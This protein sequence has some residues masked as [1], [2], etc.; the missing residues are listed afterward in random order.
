MVESFAEPTP[1]T[2]FQVRTIRGATC[3]LCALMTLLS[4]ACTGS[5]GKAKADVRAE[6]E[7]A[8]PV[9]VFTVA[10]R[11]LRRTVEAVGSLFPYDEVV[12]SSEVDGSADEVLADVRAQIATGQAL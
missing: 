4:S 6:R 5:A 10:S 11:T 8:V 3:A 7:T 1:I 12:V 9:E 2:G